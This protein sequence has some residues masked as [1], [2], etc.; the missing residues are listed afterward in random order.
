MDT[1][2]TLVGHYDG[3]YDGH[4][5]DTVNSRA[6]SAHGRKKLYFQ[7]LKTHMCILCVNSQCPTCV[8]RSVQR[9]SIECPLRSPNGHCKYTIRACV[10][11]ARASTRGCTY[12][13]PAARA[14]QHWWC[15][16]SHPRLMVDPSMPHRK[17]SRLE[18]RH[19]Q[20]VRWSRSPYA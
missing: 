8:H 4:S 14:L 3:H 7:P 19:S 2:W 10:R 9:V 20:H 17:R 16:R 11:F 18:S 6:H 13:P 15:Q 12:L 5:L 1:R